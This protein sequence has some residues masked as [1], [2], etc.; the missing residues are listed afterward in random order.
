[1]QPLNRPYYSSFTR[2][3]VVH[4]D[5]IHRC[6]STLETT[7]TPSLPL[8]Q[9]NT[10]SLS[11]PKYVR[12]IHKRCK[13]LVLAF[14]SFVLVPLCGLSTA[15]NKK[16]TVFRFPSLPSLPRRMHPTCTVIV[17]EQVQGTTTYCTQQQQQQQQRQHKQGFHSK[18]SKLL[19]G[20]SLVNGIPTGM[21]LRV[22]LDGSQM[23][24]SFRPSSMIP[25]LGNLLIQ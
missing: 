7:T 8:L 2:S 5:I 12:Y 20:I 25:L 13:C 15:W 11:A 1:M 24:V 21:G 22:C 16:K 18:P 3:V 10:K 14:R 23:V 17:C 4:S 19:H 6:S 9:L